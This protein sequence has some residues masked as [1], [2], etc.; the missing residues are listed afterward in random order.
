MGNGTKNKV[1]SKKQIDS[2]FLRFKYLSG[3]HRSVFYV[4]PALIAVYLLYLYIKSDY[5]HLIRPLFHYLIAGAFAFILT[6][7]VTP[8]TIRS[9]KK[10]GFVK[11]PDFPKHRSSDMPLLGGVSIYFVVL[12]VSLFYLPWPVEVQSIFLSAFIILLIGTI[13]DFYPL[14]S[15]I[16]LVGQIV[17]SL[18]IMS[19]GLI[20]SFLPN[21]LVGT[22]IAVII[23]FIWI[24]GIVNAANFSD[25]VDGLT[26]GMTGF[27]CVFFFLITLVSNQP[28]MALITSILAGSCM[29]FLVFNY[30]PAKIYLGD[31]GST[32]LGFFL[33]SFALYGGWSSRGIFVALGI[34]VLILGVLIFDMIYIT[35][36]RIR[37]KNVRNFKQW[38]DYRG[39]DHFHHRLMN[40]GLK[41]SEAVL[42]IYIICIILGLSSLVLEHTKYSFP[43]IILI[44]QAV[45]IFVI[46]TILMLA[47]RKISGKK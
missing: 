26:A 45:L 47:G 16:R 5:G 36:S 42:F 44:V 40:L 43:V 24:L 15:F 6:L 38:L 7:F 32:T 39:R 12:M 8:L 33:A 35:V 19:S 14:S 31:G 25:G 4:I 18:I 27:A 21:T 20:V 3:N 17:A 23:T 28:H 2:I 13:D 10:T 29:G 46:I 9:A 37:N 11:S 1:N 34:P 30:K 22:I 41:E